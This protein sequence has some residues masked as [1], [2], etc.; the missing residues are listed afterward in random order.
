[1]SIQIVLLGLLQEKSY[2]PYE[3]K[4]MII[5]NKWDH[6]F[7]VTDGNIYH[8]IR[9][10]EKH[11]WVESEKE[12]QVNNRPNRTVYRITDEGKDQLSKEIQLVFEQRLK[13]PRSLYPA[14]LFIHLSNVDEIKKM[15]QQ[16]I[17][18]LQEETSVET[19]YP[20][21]LPQ[22]INRHYSDTN[23]LYHKWLKDLLV[24]IKKS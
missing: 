24:N 23:K 10:L 17:I 4:K 13:E 19:E 7:P 8:A 22:L 1:M 11:E 9:K 20:A 2:H 15:I 5:E 6:L 14:T 3:M 18:E 12:E 21:G 16:W